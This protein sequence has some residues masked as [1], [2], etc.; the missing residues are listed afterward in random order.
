MKKHILC[1]TDFSDNAL[2]AIN[3]SAK[4]FEHHR[5]EFYILHA[6]QADKNAL[7]IE[8]LVPEPGD[9]VY[10][11]EKKIATIG[12]KKIIDSLKSNFKNTK[13]TYTAVASFNA[14]LYALKET[15]KN[16][17]IE[18]LVIG[19]KAKLE[20]EAND[21][22]PILDI[23]EYITD[24]SI[25]AVPGDYSFCELKEILLPVDYEETLETSNFTEIIG[26]AK[27]HQSDINILHIKK[28]HHLDEKQL[29]NKKQLEYILKGLK[30][31][32]HTL[33]R[34]PINKGINLFIKNEHCNLIAFI[35]EKS[36]YIGNSLPRPLLKQLNQ[37]CIPLLS[38][39]TKISK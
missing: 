15:I 22:L 3:Y 30:Y 21:D 29:E 1:Y 11:T 31:S 24:C 18:V 20:L 2:N 39:S 33:K 16:N 9:K 13:H 8:A 10:E 14:L 38:I 19:T 35:E 36:S 27:Q 17:T 25:L 26:L 34:M 23:M 7:D 5:C 6:F 37:L 28:E 32:F 12:L 4:L